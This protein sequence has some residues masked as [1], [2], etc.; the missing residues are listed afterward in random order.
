M[1]CVEQ[2]AEN[3][4]KKEGSNE[5]YLEELRHKL[6]FLKDLSIFVFI[7][8]LCLSCLAFNFSFAGCEKLNNHAS[9]SIRAKTWQ[10]GKLS[11]MCE[12]YRNQ[13]NMLSSGPATQ[14][15]SEWCRTNPFIRYLYLRI[16]DGF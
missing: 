13:W 4:E 1:L 3:K 5:M 7:S 16:M 14:I 15:K 11:C 2:E 9:L 6:V 10:L 8:S 12:K